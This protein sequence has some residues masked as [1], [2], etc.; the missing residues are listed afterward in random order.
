MYVVTAEKR[1]ELFYC[2]QWNVCRSKEELY[3]QGMFLPMTR[4]WA[5]VVFLGRGLKTGQP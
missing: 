1:A 4:A 3:S 5:S 2:S